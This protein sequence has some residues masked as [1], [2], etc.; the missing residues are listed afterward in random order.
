MKACFKCGKV[1]P[2]DNFYKHSQM[3]DG[4]L[5]KCK[6]CSRTDVS[7]NYHNNKEYYK[8]YEKQRMKL[9]HRKQASKKL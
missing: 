2:L 4:H 7:K 3:A 6:E 8:E 5:N 9:P 1:K